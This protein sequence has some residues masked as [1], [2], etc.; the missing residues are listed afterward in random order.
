MCRS[1]RR[2][3]SGR[4]PPGCPPAAAARAPPAR[5]RRTGRGDPRLRLEGTGE[6]ARREAGPRGEGLD[7]EVPVRVLGD[8]LLHVPQRLPPRRL[9]RQLRAELRLVS[10]PAQEHHQVPGDRQRHVPTVV[11]LHQR[12]REVDPRRDPGRGG[13]RPVPYVDGVRLHRHVRVVPRHLLAHVPVRRRAPPVQQPRLGE[14]QPSRAH[15]HQ[16]LRASP[17]G[18]Q[19]V[20][21][22]RLEVG[23][24]VAAG[25]E[26]R[27]PPPRPGALQVP[28]RHQRQSAARTDRRT[29]RGHGPDLVRLRPG[30]RAAAAN[31]STGPV[32]SRLWTPS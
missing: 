31:T 25:H 17:V 20:G 9:R 4:C 10:G 24:V 30:N 32:T 11:L 2:G 3:I 8:P 28:V 27:G 14:Q 19:P 15:G 21:E 12:E 23:R 1:R 16:P 29:A 18:A 22:P 13:D 5:V 26:E 6:V 7:A